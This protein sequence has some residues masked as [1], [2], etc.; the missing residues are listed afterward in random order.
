MEEESPQ[1]GRKAEIVEIEEI[2]EEEP[3]K[4]DIK[5]IEE[6]P[7]KVEG[8]LYT[9]HKL[10]QTQF[11]YIYLNF[12]NIYAF[13]LQSIFVLNYAFVPCFP[14]KSHS[15]HLTLLGRSEKPEAKE[16]IIKVQSPEPLVEEPAS[17]LTPSTPALGMKEDAEIIEIDVSQPEKPQISEVK[18]KRVSR[19]KSLQFEMIEEEELKPEHETQIIEDVSKPEQKSAVLASKEEIKTTEKTDDSEQPKIDDIPKQKPKR[20]VSATEEKCEIVEF[21]ID[22]TRRKS[23]EEEIDQKAPQKAIGASVEEAVI[24]KVEED[25]VPKTEEVPKEK[26]QRGVSVQKEEIESG[27]VKEGASKAK[28]AKVDTAVSQKGVKND[29]DEIDEEVEALLQRAKKQRSLIEEVNVKDEEP[30]GISRKHICI[31][32]LYIFSSSLYLKRVIFRSCI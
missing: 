30:E 23:I 31:R 20:G 12:V 6:T 16:K 29:D 17:P 24:R 10:L 26:V 4:P 27:Q 28:E 14:N 5:E 18:K 3:K 8:G 9:T 11:K 13:E 21:S 1:K 25:S 19:G 32:T 2:P 15:F 22:S 7:E